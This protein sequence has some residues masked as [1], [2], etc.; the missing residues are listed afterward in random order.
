MPRALTRPA[1]VGELLHPSTQLSSQPP[2]QVSLSRHDRDRG[3]RGEPW[4]WPAGLF[5]LEDSNSGF[6]TVV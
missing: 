3:R 6:R 4:D 2:W 5:H 1:R